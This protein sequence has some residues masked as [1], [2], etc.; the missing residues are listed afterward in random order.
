MNENSKQIQI[1][2]EKVKI[3]NISN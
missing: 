1:K 3:S 2:S